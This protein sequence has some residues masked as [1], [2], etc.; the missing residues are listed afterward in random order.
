MLLASL[1][2]L[3]GTYFDRI[4]DL[5]LRNRLQFAGKCRRS[6]QPISDLLLGCAVNSS[7]STPHPYLKTLMK[8]ISKVPGSTINPADISI[9]MSDKKGWQVLCDQAVAIQ[10]H[11]RTDPLALA[12]ASTKKLDRAMVIYKNV[13]V[14]KVMDYDKMTSSGQQ[15]RVRTFLKHVSAILC[16][17]CF[18]NQCKIHCQLCIYTAD[19][20]Q[21][22]DSTPAST[23]SSCNM[24]L[25]VSFAK[26]PRGCRVRKSS[27]GLP[28]QPEAKMLIS[29]A[30]NVCSECY[31]IC[32]LYPM[33]AVVRAKILNK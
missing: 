1:Q 14:P 8:D 24:C 7:C 6:D 23:Y 13:N 20:H 11:A 29:F 9:Q 33:P 32:T 30:K 31:V 21:T 16:R 10:I 15:E 18:K 4:E 22:Q 27:H 2:T 19:D 17:H 28:R 26:C 25:R 3:L 5:L 12:Q